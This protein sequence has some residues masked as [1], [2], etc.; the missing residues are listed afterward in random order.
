MLK[1]KTYTENTTDTIFKYKRGYQYCT[2]FT[3]YDKTGDYSSINPTGWGFPNITRASVTYLNLFVFNPLTQKSYVSIPP[4]GVNYD[5]VGTSF[6]TTG[7]QIELTYSLITGGQQTGN[8]P[9]GLYTIWIN[10]VQGATALSTVQVCI[11]PCDIVCE[12]NKLSEKILYTKACCETYEK[13]DLLS[14]T[15]M[16]LNYE[17]DCLNRYFEQLD[18]TSESYSAN[19]TSPSVYKKLNNLYKKCMA[20]VNGKGGCGCGCK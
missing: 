7:Y 6:F 13:Y 4:T 9:N 8:L 20:L 16:A 5:L 1:L 17:I 19:I 12:L 18:V 15:F 14:D 3:L 11:Q 2:S 10:S